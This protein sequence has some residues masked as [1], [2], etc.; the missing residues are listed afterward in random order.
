MLKASK[1]CLWKEAGRGTVV[2]VEMTPATGLYIRFMCN[3]LENSPV[4]VSWGDGSRGEFLYTRNDISAAHTYASYGHYKI[5][6]EGARSLGFRNLDGEAHYSY[7]AA[8]TSYVDYSGLVTGSRSGA[9]KRAVNLKRF[10]APGLTGFGQR[11]FA[12]CPKLQEV[13][14]P[15]AAY[16][17]DGVFQS[18]PNIETLTL[19]GGT[20]WSYVF[21]D[22]TK[23][24]EIRFSSV[25]QISTQCFDGCYELMDI[26]IANKTVDQ[27]MQRASSGNI[28]AGY[29]A[30][31]P[32][33]A[34]ASCR[35]H[36]ID[37]VVLGN[38]T[39]V[40]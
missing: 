25:D 12:Y 14:T 2:E 31:F 32:W 20:M 30:R 40:S 19:T 35:F 10:I 27:I 1:V 15:R 34:N 28:E 4:T 37:G 38:G 6:F 5:V 39:R 13:Q 7:D 9:F 3:A 21:K 22:C 17:Y 23:L 24:R 11:D 8:I 26:W 33:N 29:G 18:C 36:G 16:F